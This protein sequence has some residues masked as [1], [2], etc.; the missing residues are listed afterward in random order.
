MWQRAWWGCD[1]GC[2]GGH[3]WQGGVHG[4]GGC[5]AGVGGLGGGLCTAGE[6]ATAADVTHPTGM[7]SCYFFSFDDNTNVL[8]Q[9]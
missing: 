2:G 6:T 5:V 8:R 3:M 9:E 4:Q 7:H 1:W